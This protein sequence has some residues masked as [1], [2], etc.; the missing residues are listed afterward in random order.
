M[1][2]EHPVNMTEYWDGLLTEG[3]IT[4]IKADQNMIDE[5][6]LKKHIQDQTNGYS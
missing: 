5:Y 2:K 6:W 1:S 4:Q 3:L